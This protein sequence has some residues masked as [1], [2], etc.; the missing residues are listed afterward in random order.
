V[1][2]LVVMPFLLIMSGLVM[3]TL[4][5]AYGAQSQ[6]QNASNASSQVTL[7]FMQLDSEIRYAADINTPWQSSNNYL[8]A[9]ESDWKQ[10]AQ[11]QSLC[12]QL[13]YDTSTGR[14]LQGSWYPPATA[15]TG[16]QVL[17]SGL[18]TSVPIDPFSLSTPQGSPW[19][20]SIGTQNA[21]IWAV[22]GTGLSTGK[23]ESR[24]TIA[25]LDTTSSSKDQ[26]VCGGPSS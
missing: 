11:G 3:W 9:F 6:V 2:L 14:L 22:G 10:N 12:T 5:T 23:A 16:W 17:A 4:A 1:E 18:Q 26:G 24:F 20:L 13:K 25:A 7:A 21:P 19:L 15:P 8:V